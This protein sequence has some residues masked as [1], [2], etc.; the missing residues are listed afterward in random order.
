MGKDVRGISPKALE[1]LENYHY[2][3]NVRELE[4]IIARC[5]ALESSNVIRQE[6]LP[7][8][9]TGRDYL[10]LV[11]VLRPARVSIRFLVMLK[12]R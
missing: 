12:R 2:P 6:T 1:V 10:D 8:L 9:V 3:G 4:N 11:R 5:V 7:Q